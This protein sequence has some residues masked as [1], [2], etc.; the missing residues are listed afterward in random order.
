MGLKDRVS[1]HGGPWP[2][3][4]RWYLQRPVLVTFLIADTKHSTRNKASEEGF[5]WF[6]V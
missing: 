6:T 2:L 3:H 4:M 1:F 5:L